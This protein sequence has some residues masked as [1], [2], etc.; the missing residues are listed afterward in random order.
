MLQVNK[1]DKIGEIEGKNS[2]E[3]TCKVSSFSKKDSSFSKKD[4]LRLL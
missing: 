2:C 1:V 3:F 4:E